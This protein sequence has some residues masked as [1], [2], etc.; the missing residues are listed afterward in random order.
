[1]TVIWKVSM[2]SGQLF[3]GPV[4]ETYWG[5]TLDHRLIFGLAAVV[6]MGI[7]MVAINFDFAWIRCGEA[8]AYAPSVAGRSEPYVGHSEL[9]QVP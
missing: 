2:R 8:L 4:Q 1:M 9:N 6:L 3:V 5:H 7:D